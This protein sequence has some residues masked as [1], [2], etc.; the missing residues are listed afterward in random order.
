MLFHVRVTGNDIKIIKQLTSVELVK[1]TSHIS[2][3][4]SL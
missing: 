2:L 3:L 1:T 4:V